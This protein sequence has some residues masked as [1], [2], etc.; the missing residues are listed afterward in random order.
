MIKKLFVVLLFAI[1]YFTTAQ[2]I[3]LEGIVQ[4]TI[5]NPLEMANVMVINQETKAMDG[6][7]I[8]N[9]QGKFQISLKANSTYQ[10]KVS[11]LGY[12]PLN[13]ELITGTENIRKVLA[14]KE[15]GMMLDGVEVVQ[16]MPVSISGDTI[17]Y[18]ADSFKTG[19]EQKLEDILKKLPGVQ[20]NEDCEIDLEGRK[21]SQLLVE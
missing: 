19:T 15:G 12:Q 1:S 8:S 3:K 13:I 10:I 5:G 21:V 6:Y 2:N 20:V 11:F 9:E 18:N 14:L 4:D 17:I 7:A 16:E